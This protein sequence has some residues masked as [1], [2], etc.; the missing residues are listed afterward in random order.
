MN[1]GLSNRRARAYYA[2]RARGGAGLIITGGTAIDALACEELWGGTEGLQSF[3]ARLKAL[4]DEV[5]AC[6]ARIGIQLWQGNRFPE[7]KDMQSSRPDA[8]DG[9]LVAPSAR[10]NMRE[11]TVPEI[12]SIIYR[13]ARASRNV[14]DAGFDCVELHGAH[15][16][17]PCQFTSP[18][19]NRRTDKYGGDPAGRMRF[20]TDLVAAARAWVGPDFPV[21]FRLGAL[22]QDGSIHR[23]SLT[24][25]V[26][27]EKAGV[28]CINVSTS[29]WGGFPMSPAKHYEMG[30]LVPLAEAVK[31]V[32]TVPV[33][34]VGRINT[35]EVAEEI[36]KWG[37]ADMV[38]IARQLIADP[39]W[40]LKVLEGRPEEI[41]TCD[42]CNANCFAPT[43]GRKLKEGAPLCKVNERV[44]REWETAAAG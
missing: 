29:G 5:H 6:G 20:G 19:L 38:A 25:A 23:D 28:D 18:E 3:M 27:L 31:K 22:D 12:E 32:V 10:D 36:L 24:Y 43:T 14:R 44:G 37:Q 7:G 35:Q 40:P 13:F 30:T 9:D 42:S 34:G 41:V 16:Y 4:A 26:E 39:F 8:G 15:A 1:V 2:E 21:F 17:L 11:L 33:I